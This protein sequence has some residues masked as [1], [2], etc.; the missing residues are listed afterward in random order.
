MWGAVFGGLQPQPR[1]YNI[2]QA[3]PYPIFPKIHPHL[4]DV[5]KAKSVPICP[6]TAFQAAKT[7]CI[8][9][10]FSLAFLPLLSTTMIG[11]VSSILPPPLSTTTI[12]DKDR[13]RCRRH[14][15]P[16]HLTMTAI[17][18]VNEDNQHCERRQSAPLAPSHQMNTCANPRMHTGIC[19]D[20]ANPYAYRDYMTCNPRMYTGIKINPRMHTEIACHV[21]PVCI[22]GSRC[23]PRMHMGIDLDPHMH[24]GICVTPI[25][26]RGSDGH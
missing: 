1:S 15:L 9:S 5:L 17:T 4:H 11:A 26:I 24:T 16:L 20:H 10:I 18:A 2:T 8:D 25:C 14:Q 3:W 21:I 22:R 19:G 23:N 13:H 6:S 12:M 7:L